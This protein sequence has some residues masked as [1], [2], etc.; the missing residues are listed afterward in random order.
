[1]LTVAGIALAGPRCVQWIQTHHDEGPQWG[2]LRSAAQSPVG[3]GS[4]KET[5]GKN[6]MRYFQR[7]FQIRILLPPPPSP[8]RDYKNM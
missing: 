3:T 8:S 4:L 6:Q 5:Q 7:T 2:R 1:M